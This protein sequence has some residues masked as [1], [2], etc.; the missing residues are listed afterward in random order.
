MSKRLVDAQRSVS[1]T[2]RCSEVVLHIFCEPYIFLTFSNTDA[3]VPSAIAHQSHRAYGVET[4]VF[5][6]G[7]HSTA[8]MGTVTGSSRITDLAVLSILRSNETQMKHI[9]HFHLHSALVVSAC[10]CYYVFLDSLQ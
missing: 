9:A 4:G 1:D 2:L 6:L 8:R 3:P 5:S 10:P 7:V